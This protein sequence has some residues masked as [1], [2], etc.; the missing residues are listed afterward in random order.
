MLWLTCFG[1]LHVPRKKVAQGAEAAVLAATLAASAIKAAPV[2][3]RAPRRSLK[4]WWQEKKRRQDELRCQ[5]EQYL[6]ARNPLNQAS[7]PSA[8]IM[9][10][11]TTA[12]EAT[13]APVR[14]PR[15]PMKEAI[16]A[17]RQEEKRRQ[18]E[19]RCQVEKR[20]A[21]REKALG[22]P[23]EIFFGERSGAH[24][25]SWCLVLFVA[26]CGWAFFAMPSS[27]GDGVVTRLALSVAV[28]G[29]LTAAYAISCL[30]IVPAIPLLLLLLPLAFVSLLAEEWWRIYHNKPY[31]PPTPVVSGYHPDPVQP[32]VPPQDDGCN[33]AAPFFIG[34]WLGH[35]WGS[36]R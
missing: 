34:L 24:M 19:R 21:A 3:V 32:S 12:I 16:K 20:R 5:A 25:A 17:G 18:D 36:D 28:V 30:F 1:A 7:A 31:V 26:A 33:S 15:K 11:A 14:T 13:P 27:E 8:E 4:A 23:S 29:V 10:L 6:R 22:V 35:M 9:P 2:P